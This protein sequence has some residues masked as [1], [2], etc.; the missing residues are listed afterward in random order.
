MCSLRPIHRDLV[1]KLLQ[2]ES[3]EHRGVSCEGPGRGCRDCLRSLIEWRNALCGVAHT[4]GC[5]RPDDG[6]N[7]QLCDWWPDYDSQAGH[8][9]FAG[10]AA[11]NISQ[12]KND[13]G[14]KGAHKRFGKSKDLS[15]DFV[16]QMADF[17]AAAGMAVSPRCLKDFDR[18]NGA[19]TARHCGQGQPGTSEASTFPRSPP[20]TWSQTG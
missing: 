16:A 12:Q 11:L 1:V 5:M 13:A 8:V 15:L 20:L 6:H 4:I 17:H 14:R 9:E 10:G 2:Y 7:G 19:V 3:R 18:Q